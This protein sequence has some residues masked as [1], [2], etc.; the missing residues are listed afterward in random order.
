VAALMGKR[1]TVTGQEP[2]EF[3]R[4]ELVSRG[5]AAAIPK[6]EALLSYAHERELVALRM[7]HAERAM[8]LDAQQS[9]VSYRLLAVAFDR[10]QSWVIEQLRLA[11]EEAA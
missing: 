1:G 3:V 2:L 11:R 10:P 4:D 5:K 6:L 8:M 7:E 9:G